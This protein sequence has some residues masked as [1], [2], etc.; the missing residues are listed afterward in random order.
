VSG[1]PVFDAA[2]PILPGFAAPVEFVFWCESLPDPGRCGAGTP[3]PVFFPKQ[4]L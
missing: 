3:A 4:L 2:A 1:W